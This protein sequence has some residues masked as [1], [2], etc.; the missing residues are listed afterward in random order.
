M[1]CD[2]VVVASYGGFDDGLDWNHSAKVSARWV[3]LCKWHCES[4]REQHSALV[5]RYAD[6]RRSIARRR[7]WGRDP[8]RIQLRAMAIA[9][10]V[11][12]RSSASEH[13]RD[14]SLTRKP[15]IHRKEAPPD[16]GMSSGTSVSTSTCSGL[17]AVR[18][19]PRRT[20]MICCSSSTVIRRRNASAML[21]G[22]PLRVDASASL[23]AIVFASPFR[24]P[25][26]RD[27]YLSRPD[28]VRSAL[29]YGVPCRPFD[30]LMASG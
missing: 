17:S 24:C 12:N 5:A 29:L 18:Q 28:D 7:S 13:R 26:P 19:R 21:G 27:A 15:V 9:R 1:A 4:L 11:K 25:L 8:V 23:D 14:I 16:I 6:H 2:L 3:A 22:H 10:C 20:P 30:V